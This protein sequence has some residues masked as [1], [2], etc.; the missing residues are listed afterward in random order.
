MCMDVK[1]FY[2]NNYMDRSEYIMIQISMIPQKIVDKYNLKEKY[3][4]GYIFA[5]VTK[6][7]HGLPQ[8]G[9]IPNDTIV[10]HLENYE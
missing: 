3:H 6:E 10:K 7:I 4:N 1:Y 2:L 9:R 5:R 8:A